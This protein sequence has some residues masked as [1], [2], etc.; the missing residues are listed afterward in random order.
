M[1]IWRR[2]SVSPVTEISADSFSTCCHTLPMPGSAKRSAR[3]AM[4][5]RSINRRDMPTARAASISPPGMAR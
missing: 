1:W 5:R 2:I 4:I 3:G